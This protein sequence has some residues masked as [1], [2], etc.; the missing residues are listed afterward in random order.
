VAELKISGPLSWLRSRE[1]TRLE[2]D[3]ELQVAGILVKLGFEVV[4]EP[5]GDT[6]FDLRASKHDKNVLVEVKCL[7][8]APLAYD[9]V[10]Q[11]HQSA[12]RLRKQG[13]GNVVPIIVGSFDVAEGVQEV[14]KANSVNLIAMSGRS[15]TSKLEEELEKLI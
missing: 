7:G 1:A 15:T 10:A 14:A 8:S 11:V 2:N 13:Q 12:E 6:G 5:A 4:R 9:A 3:I